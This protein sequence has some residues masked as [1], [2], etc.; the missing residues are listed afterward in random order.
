M[1][2]VGELD[3]YDGNSGKLA[4]VPKSP[5]KEDGRR[6]G[7]TARDRRTHIEVLGWMRFE[8]LEEFAIGVVEAF[9][10]PLLRGADDPPARIGQRD[11][12]H[13]RHLGRARLQQ[14]MRLP[15]CEHVTGFIRVGGTKPGH[16]LLQVYERGVDR[17]DGASRLFRQDRGDVADVVASLIDRVGAKTP[18]GQTDGD[19]GTRYESGG[20]P[21]WAPDRVVAPPRHC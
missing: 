17:F 1:A 11:D 3:R 4:R 21:N 10:W 13:M 18:D 19:D 5:D 15:A 14:L 16:A 9:G 12:R 6:P 20:D 7:Y 2:E 8:E